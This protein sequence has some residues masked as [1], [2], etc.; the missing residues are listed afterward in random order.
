MTQI[1]SFAFATLKPTGGYLCKIGNATEFSKCTEDQIC[2]L[3]A[4]N[5][6]LEYHYDKSSIMNFE[7]WYTRLHLECKPFGEYATISSSY[8]IGFASGIIFLFLP[9]LIGR[10]GTMAFVLPC[11]ALISCLSVLSDDLN[12]KKIGYFLQGLFHIKN[13][14]SFTHMYELVPQSSKVMA[15]TLIMAY[16]CSTLLIVC[17]FIKFGGASF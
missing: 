7:N 5:Q 13:S 16:D 2:S 11:Y 3:R 15:A 17:G 14:N 1:Y 12:M 10:Y 8:F 9:D 4:A 6:K